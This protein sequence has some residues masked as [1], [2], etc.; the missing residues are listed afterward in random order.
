MRT[1]SN[2]ER[3]KKKR[4]QGE[5]GREGKNTSDSWRW[6]SKIHTHLSVVAISKTQLASLSTN[7][8]DNNPSHEKLCVCVC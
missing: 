7:A 1:W 6:E 3:R 2:T 8:E 5:G 4:A